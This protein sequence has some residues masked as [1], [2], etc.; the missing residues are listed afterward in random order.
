[1]VPDPIYEEWLQWRSSFDVLSKKH[2]PRCY[3][4][5]GTPTVFE[6]YGFSDASENAY[7]AVVYLRITDTFGRTQISFVLSKAKVAP[8]KTLTIPRLELCGAYLLAQLLF[9]IKNV[10]HMPLNSVY[11]WT[12]STIVL[13]WLVGNQRRFKN[14]R[15]NRVSYIVKLIALDRRSHI[16]SADYPVD[17]AS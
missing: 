1:M 7:A 6:L 15:G 13:S 17:C 2:I 11:A 10:F 5:K 9:Y 4:N 3:L 16:E 14:Y 8:I 12:D